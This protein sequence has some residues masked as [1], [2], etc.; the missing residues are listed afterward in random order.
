M[1]TDGRGLSGGKGN[2]LRIR[3]GT[4]I[5]R[6]D[7]AVRVTQFLDIDGSGSQSGDGDLSAGIGS[8]R[9]GNECGTGSI[10][11]N[12]ELPSGQIQAILGSLGQTQSAKIQ[13]VIE[14]DG[15]GA[16]AANSNFLRIR[17]GTGVQRID[18]AV[19]MAQ[20]LHIVGSCRKSCDR[21]LTAG[22]GGVWAGNQFAAGSIRSSVPIQ[23]MSA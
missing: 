10:R 18:T 3:A 15:S 2:S 22:I 5:Q 7:A 13:L 23:M 20:F 12:P 8:M 9:S 19:G 21:N 17:A 1:E 16:S 14:A 4:A 11:I 6:I